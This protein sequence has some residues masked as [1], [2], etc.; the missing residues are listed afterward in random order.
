MNAI[1]SHDPVE[2]LG[3]TRCQNDGYVI[4]AMADA[5]D[6]GPQIEYV[7]RDLL[8]KSGQQVGPVNGEL[9]GAIA[10]LGSVRHLQRRRDLAGIPGAADA[11]RGPRRCAS[12]RF[13]YA[14]LVEGVDGIGRQIDVCADPSE[15]RRLL[16]DAG[17]MAGTAQRQ[18]R[19]ESADA[20]TDDSNPQCHDIVSLME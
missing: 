17:L 4:R 19:Y 20:S 2:R 5:R 14:E 12:E 8:F 15:T 13:A 3:L 11:M 7:S 6:L 10:A 16:E 9:R 18:R 1:R